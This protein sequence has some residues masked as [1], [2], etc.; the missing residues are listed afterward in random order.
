MCCLR[1]ETSVGLF[2]L[3]TKDLPYK[4]NS[5]VLFAE[6]SE[7]LVLEALIFWGLFNS[8]QLLCFELNMQIQM[9]SKSDHSVMTHYNSP[10]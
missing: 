1:I 5:N 4:Q 6:H 3:L 9:F 7:K 8:A 2:I 10:V